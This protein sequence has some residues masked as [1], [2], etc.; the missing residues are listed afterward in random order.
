MSAW[1]SFIIAE[2]QEIQSY[3]RKNTSSWGA[4]TVNASTNTLNAE[5]GYNLLT[6]GNVGI[7]TTS[8]D[9]PLNINNGSTSGVMLRAESTSSPVIAVLDDSGNSGVLNLGIATTT[10]SLSNI[11]SVGDA[12][13]RTGLNALGAGGN[14]ILT[15]ARTATGG[16]LF[17]TQS[18][19]TEKMIITNAG[20]VGIGTTTPNSSAVLDLSGKTTSMLIPVGTTGQEPTCN[21]ALAGGIRY[22]STTAAPEYCNGSAWI[23]FDAVGVCAPSCNNVTISA[24]TA[25][26]NLFTLAGKV[27]GR[28]EIINSRSTLAWSSV[29]RAPQRLAM[30]TE[31]WRPAGSKLWLVNKGTIIGAGGTGGTGGETSAGLS[32]GSRRHRR[33]PSSIHELSSYYHEHWHN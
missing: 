7:G 5:G 12:I 30:V 32:T 10:G 25:N 13:I 27:R 8:P 14:L 24:S 19:D 15:A 26:V 29:L 9:A 16:I 17:S 23:P 2:L 6:G 28:R 21:T 3:N 31:A 20:N 11:A 22:N 4:F 18:P 1:S 33:R